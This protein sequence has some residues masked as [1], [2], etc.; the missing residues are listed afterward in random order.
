METARWLDEREMAAWTAFV[1]ASNLVER[2][3][4]QQL[5]DE[6]GL[7]HQQYEILVRLSDA[8]DGV[9][10]MSELAERLV[11][12]KSGLTYQIGQLEKAGLVRR[13]ACP[14][15]E[16]GVNAVLTEQGSRKLR[17]VAPGHVEIV[18]ACLIDTLSSEQRDELTDALSAV[19]RNLRDA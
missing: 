7:S 11:T 10:R 19:T 17:D 15:D 12:S 14:G 18:R 1:E 2:R 16:R 13:E 4:Q 9:V 6:A 3:V 8:P 5:R